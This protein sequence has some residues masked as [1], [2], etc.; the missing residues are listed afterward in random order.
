M[1][2]EF[3]P[4]RI[5][6]L[7]SRIFSSSP[8]LLFS[9]FF[10]R[11]QRICQKRQSRYGGKRGVGEF[12]AGRDTDNMKEIGKVGAGGLYGWQQR[13]RRHYK[14]NVRVP[15]DVF[16]FC[17]FE[18]GIDGDDNHANLRRGIIRP[19]KRRA[20]GQQQ[21]DFIARLMPSANNPALRRFTIAA[22]SANVCG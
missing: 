22:S 7:V 17:G 1:R 6:Y 13:S 5:S 10:P 18:E 12:F 8:F 4:S 15:P 14:F 20:I 9:F 19:H 3:F 21:A 16:Q 11:S 2:D